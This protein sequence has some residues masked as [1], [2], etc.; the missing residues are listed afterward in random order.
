MD[1]DLRTLFTS[2]VWPQ[3][4][5]PQATCSEDQ[6]TWNGVNIAAG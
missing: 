2:S 6:P 1:P 3:I 5:G 4:T